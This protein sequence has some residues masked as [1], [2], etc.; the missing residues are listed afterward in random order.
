MQ[1][2]IPLEIDGRPNPIAQHGA[3]SGPCPLSEGDNPHGL[4][5][6]VET[7][8]KCKVCGQWFS[9]VQAGDALIVEH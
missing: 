6:H 4:N 2:I 8:R 1:I 9:V 5:I 3:Y 7:E